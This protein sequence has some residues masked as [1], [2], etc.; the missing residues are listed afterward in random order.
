VPKGVFTAQRVGQF[1]DIEGAQEFGCGWPTTAGNQSTGYNIIESIAPYG[2][3]TL[4]FSVC[5][6]FAN[7]RVAILSA[8]ALALEMQRAIVLPKLLLDGTQ[9]TTDE[10]NEDSSF[11]VSFE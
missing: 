10:I 3:R 11:S 4:S 5:N 6:G 9:Y 2:S 7:Q 8:L 1:W